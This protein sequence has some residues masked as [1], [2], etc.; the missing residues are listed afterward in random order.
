MLFGKKQKLY[1]EEVIDRTRQAFSDIG[2]SE[3]ANMPAI[4]LKNADGRFGII[5]NESIQ[6]GVFIIQDRSSV[7]ATY[8]YKTLEEFL[9]DG[10]VVD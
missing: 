9:A 7:R 1:P 5:L 8:N 4:C 6:N 2:N 10:W 3:L